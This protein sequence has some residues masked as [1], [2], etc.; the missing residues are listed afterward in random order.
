MADNATIE[1]T[2]LEERIK[3][4]GEAS[5]KNP[6]MRRRINEVIREMMKEV[7]KKL[8]DNAQSGLQMKED[9]RKAY[10][11]IKMAVYRKIFGGNVSILSPIR[12][13]SMRLYA[14]P[15]KGTSDPKGRGGNRMKRSGRTTEMM[16]YQGGDRWMVLQWLNNGTRDRFSGSGRNGKTISQYNAFIERTG[17]RGK[18]GHISA[19]NWFGQKS[20][21]EIMSA[22]ANLDKMLDDIVSG[23]LY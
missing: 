7:R 14:P 4:F 16:S 20:T 17:G 2:G 10:K 6:E 21:Q 3:K 23:I 13:R 22:A 11:A 8:Q 18:R 12:A 1:I 19:R 15:R 5:T 9:P